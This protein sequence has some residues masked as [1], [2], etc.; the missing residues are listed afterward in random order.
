MARCSEVSAMIPQ[1]G[2]LPLPLPLSRR[3][4]RISSVFFSQHFSP[5]D[6]ISTSTAGCSPMVVSLTQKH[7]S[8]SWATLWSYRRRA[9]YYIVAFIL[10]MSEIQKPLLHPHYLSS[11]KNWFPGYKC[12]LAVKF[13]W[14][15]EL[16]CV[17]FKYGQPSHSV[18]F[19]ICFCDIFPFP[20]M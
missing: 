10:V 12:N 2:P 16:C 18:L 8:V 6:M 17:M 19:S 7:F 14:N 11:P 5:T 15:F 9:D 3:H 20:F 4:Q 1:W 13:V